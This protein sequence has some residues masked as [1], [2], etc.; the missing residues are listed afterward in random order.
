[1]QGSDDHTCQQNMK[2]QAKKCPLKLRA[3]EETQLEEEFP[4][5]Q[6]FLAA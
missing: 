6:T 3:N 2:V 1:M 5:I 4:V